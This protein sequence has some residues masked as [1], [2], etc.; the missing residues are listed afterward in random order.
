M[1][2]LDTDILIDFS[3]GDETAIA[4]LAANEAA[5]TLAVNTI[6]VLEFLQGSRDKRDWQICARSLL[7]YKHLPLTAEISLLAPI[8]FETYRL[9]HGLALGDCLIAA[10]AL[11]WNIPLLTGNQRDYRFIDG[12]QLL[13]YPPTP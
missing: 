8:L 9:S 12:L 1:I 10:T 7:R 3:R 2:L 11:T 13:P 6:T 4:T 5:D